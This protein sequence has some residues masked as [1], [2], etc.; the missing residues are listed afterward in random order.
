[1]TVAPARAVTRTPETAAEEPLDTQSAPNDLTAADHTAE[2][3]ESHADSG[4]GDAEDSVTGKRGRRRLSRV[5]VFGFLPLMCLVLAATA[6]YVRW[7]NYSSHS[8]PQAA[9]E[10]MRAAR[11]ATVAM[12]SYRPD[13]A[14]KDLGAAQQR[15]T[16]N[17]KD[18]YGSL[19][20]DVVI[21]GAKQKAIT[22]VANVA[23]AAPVSV[24]ERHAVVLV[25]VNQTITMG[26]DPPTDTASSVRVTL[27]NI[28]GRWLISAFDPV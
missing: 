11:D 7:Q 3:P 4:L 23:A 18:V 25:F 26:S 10:S 9:I 21:P 17:F 8:T 24:S 2:P 28:D 15:L 6:G 27:D 5:L 1:M 19:V 14:D 20:H 13:T 12:L 22:A 16:G